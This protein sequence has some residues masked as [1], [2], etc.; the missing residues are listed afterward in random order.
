MSDHAPPWTFGVA[1]LMRNLARRGLLNDLGGEPTMATGHPG[2]EAHEGLAPLASRYV[3][4]DKH[5]MGRDPLAGRRHQ[6]A[7]GGQGNRPDD[8]ADA[9][10]ARCRRCPITSTSTSSR[11]TC[12]KA[13]SPTTRGWRPRAS[14]VWRPAGN[15]HTAHAKDG[16]I[17]LSFFLKPNKFFD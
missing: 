16:C 17:A 3:D 10:C 8:G 9:V 2:S 6:G 14:Y 11:A 15:R 12:S 13:R 5:A 4:V 1:D 7:D